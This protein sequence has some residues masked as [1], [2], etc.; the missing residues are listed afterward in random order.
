METKLW[1]PESGKD[2]MGVVALPK[3]I[4]SLSLARYKD[5]LAVRISS[6]IEEADPETMEASLSRIDDLTL[7]TDPNRAAMTLIEGS[8]ALQEATGMLNQRWPATEFPTVLSPTRK[9]WME[10]TL[11]EYVA[12]LA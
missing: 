5:Q 10:Q 6:L 8:E 4:K 2:W 9:Q 7:P 12:A 1:T 3:G 11:E